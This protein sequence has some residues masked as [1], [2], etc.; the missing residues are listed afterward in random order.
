MKIVDTKRQTI[1]RNLQIKNEKTKSNTKLY[2]WELQGP[3]PKSHFGPVWKQP[4][5]GPKI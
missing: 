3:P 4:G 2:L 5:L 1:S